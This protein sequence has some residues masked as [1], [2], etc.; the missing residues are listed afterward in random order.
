MKHAQS[1]EVARASRRVD[2]LAE[3]LSLLANGMERLKGAVGGNGVDTAG[4]AIESTAKSAGASVRGA[5]R[6]LQD[7]SAATLRGDLMATLGWHPGTT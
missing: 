5:G 7:S 3:L 1:R 2:D 6:H 4:K